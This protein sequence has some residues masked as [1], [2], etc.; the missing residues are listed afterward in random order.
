GLGTSIRE[1]ATP[2]VHVG[3]FAKYEETAAYTMKMTTATRIP[4]TSFRNRNKPYP[5]GHPNEKSRI[6]PSPAGVVPSGSARADTVWRVLIPECV[7]LTANPFD[8]I[9]DSGGGGVSV[10]AW[11][12]EW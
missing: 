4:I 7:H 3:M 8:S 2:G 1:Y 5:P 12:P 9:R 11:R 10:L 6:T